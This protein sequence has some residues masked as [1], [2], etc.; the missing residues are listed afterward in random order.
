[1]FNS[2]ASNQLS[3][4]HWYR[5]YGLNCISNVA[6]PG[7][8]PQPPFGPQAPDVVLELSSKAPKWVDQVRELPASIRYS[9]PPS[10]ETSDP[11]YGVLVRG[12]NEAFELTY[13][14]GAQFVINDQATQI[15]SMSNASLSEADVA[16][17]IRGPLM[18]FLLRLR[19]VISLHASAVSLAG[20]TV[21]LCGPS[22]SG[23]STTAAALALA[24]SPV[25]CDDITALKETD[26][27]F[28]VQPGYP[29]ICLWPDTVQQLC[30]APNALPPLTEKWEKRYL[31]L[32]KRRATFEP[33]AQPLGA[34]YILAPRISEITAPRIEDMTPR[35]A[36][37]ELVKNTYMNWVLDRALRAA[38][39]DSAA[40]I[41]DSVRIRRVV[42]HS[43]P[44]R[45]GALCELI[46]KDA[47]DHSPIS[48]TS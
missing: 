6:I 21:A 44:K 28:E 42:A 12:V 32:D 26:F 15:W 31:P 41:V 46:V 22:E 20:R 25:L 13:S 5:V 47:A 33:Y 14:D 38:E 8:Y 11:G 35:E 29:K 40:K 39:F 36:F 10:L 24:G 27:G 4:P 16:V 37:L 18:G 30:G 7:F 19:G 23:K 9:Q 48:K 1:M 3:Y 17:Y 45:I 2:P 43:D 34:I